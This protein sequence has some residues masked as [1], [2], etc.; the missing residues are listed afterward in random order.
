MRINEVGPLPITPLEPRPEIDAPRPIRPVDTIPAEGR[1]PGE[2]RQP[3]PE[4]PTPAPVVPTVNRRQG[5]RRMGERRQRQIPVL[6]D[7]R[8]ADRR[9]AR[10][11]E[12]DPPPPS[13]DIQA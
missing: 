9:V 8:V 13:V 3:L 1:T 11:R 10:R 7:T 5:D 4:E 12:D 2:E 6:I